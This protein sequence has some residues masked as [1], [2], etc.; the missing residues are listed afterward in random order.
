MNLLEHWIEEIHEEKPYEAAWTKEFTHKEFV[1]VDVTYDCYGRTTREK[2]VFSKEEWE[3][4][5]KDR[6][7]MA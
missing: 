3:K 5:K 4:C 7:F 6:Y 1:Q 2:I